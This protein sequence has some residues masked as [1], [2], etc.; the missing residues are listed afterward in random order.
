MAQMKCTDLGLL[1][2]SPSKVKLKAKPPADSVYIREFQRFSEKTQESTV[3][4]VGEEIKVVTSFYTEERDSW[5]EFSDSLKRV[6][7]KVM[8]V[9]PAPSTLWFQTQACLKQKPMGLF[10]LSLQRMAPLA[11]L[12]EREG[13]E[14]PFDSAQIHKW[15]RGAGEGLSFDTVGVLGP[16]PPHSGLSGARWSPQGWPVYMA[17]ALIA[18][19]AW[20]FPEVYQQSQRIQIHGC[21]FNGGFAVPTCGV[22]ENT[23][24]RPGKTC[25][26]ELCLSS[27]ETLVEQTY[28]DLKSET[29]LTQL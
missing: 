5:R 26:E 20:L 15:G 29:P 22:K 18:P 28:P 8:C 3:W 1:Q 27:S 21:S 12:C 7:R 24:F 9:K 16:G 14:W 13:P 10:Y 25:P 4:G 17:N 11:S 6:T 23:D 19:N 2:L